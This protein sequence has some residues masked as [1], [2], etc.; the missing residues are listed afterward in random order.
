MNAH[1][2]ALVLAP[3]L[4]LLPHAACS[5]GPSGSPPGSTTTNPG[6]NPA[7]ADVIF[8]GSATD[9][10]LTAMLA[11]QAMD[12]PANA[13]YFDNPTDLAELPGTPVITFTWHDGQKGA[14]QLLPPAFPRTWTGALGELLGERTAW[15]GT[16]AMSGKG[17][18]L[19]FGSLDTGNELFRVFTSSTSYTPDATA[20]AKIATGTWTTLQVTSATFAADQVAAGGGPING[21]AIKFCI[22]T[23][24]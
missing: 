14:L 21:Q 5:S 18:L 13:P 19:V 12:D 9:T 1:R 11:A 2:F 23:W 7:Y 8:Q 6:P 16:P 10:A 20:W 15:A 3:L 22:G 24:Q 17:Y 4:L